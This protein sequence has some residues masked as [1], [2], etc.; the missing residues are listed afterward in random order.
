MALAVGARLA[1]V[2]FPARRDKSRS[3]AL[4]QMCQGERGVQGDSVPLP[5]RE[6][7]SLPF[8]SPPAKKQK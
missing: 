8:S 7:S 2:A 5:E 6:V 1:P 4:A 3:Y